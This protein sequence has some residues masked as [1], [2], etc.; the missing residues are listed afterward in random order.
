MKPPR[1]HASPA[2]RAAL[3]ALLLLSACVGPRQP[4]RDALR[5]GD[6]TAARAAYADFAAAEGV[7]RALLAEVAA[8]YLERV[9]REGGHDDAAQALAQLQ[10]AGALA[11]DTLRRLGGLEIDPPRPPPHDLVR[12]R[13]LA[14]LA[15]RR[16]EQA[17]PQA[18]ALLYAR[19][20]HR[21]PEVVAVALQV[22]DD[23]DRLRERL[24][25]P[26]ASVRRAAALRLGTLGVAS[27]EVR[28]ALIERALVDDARPVRLAAVRALSGCEESCGGVIVALRDR[29]NDADEQVR[30]AAVRALVRVDRTEAQALFG[31]ALQLVP[32]PASLELARTFIFTRGDEPMDGIAEDGFRHLLAGLQAE[33]PSLRSQAAIALLGLPT[34]L[35]DPTPLME[36]IAHETDPFARIALAR[37]LLPRA[38]SHDLALRALGELLRPSASTRHSSVARAQAALLL[39]TEGEG[40]LAA[41]ARAWLARGLTHDERLVREVCARGVARELGRP[42]EVVFLLDDPDPH[43][44]IHVAGSLMAG[45]ASR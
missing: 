12:A 14:I 19:I 20:D 18:R 25:H 21:D 23:P 11:T 28:R 43:V 26:T 24:A 1:H 16:G 3:S 30:L 22:D 6:V 5:R 33:R 10:L 41:H 27:A 7:D 31:D 42:E 39:A 15:R 29:R 45:A 9:A 2:P 36:A 4:V 13:A 37:G 17:D 35:A 44:R 32:T 38:E 40:D 34:S 8:L